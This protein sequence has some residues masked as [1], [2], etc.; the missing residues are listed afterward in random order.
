VEDGAEDEA[1][2]AFDCA[3][4]DV[5]ADSGT[6]DV[7]ETELIMLVLLLHAISTRPGKILVDEHI[8]I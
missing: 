6:A 7:E 4:L 2:G 1:G 8:V 3:A 5:I